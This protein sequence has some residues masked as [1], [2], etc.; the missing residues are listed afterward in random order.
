MF[1]PIGDAADVSIAF[2]PAKPDS[3]RCAE[4]LDQGITEMRA[5]GE[6]GKILAKCGLTDWVK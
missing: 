1:V 4:I 5:S 6:L 2:S 3:R